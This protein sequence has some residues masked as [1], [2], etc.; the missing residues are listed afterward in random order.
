MK[1][2]RTAICIAALA[3]GGAAAARTQAPSLAEEGGGAAAAS[4]LRCA[5]VEMP[6][7]RIISTRC[8][9][10]QGWDMLGVDLKHK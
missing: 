10:P 8:H 7:S 9:T 1:P 5:K 4:K 6:G 3:L 2:I